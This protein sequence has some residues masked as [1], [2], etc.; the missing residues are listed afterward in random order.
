[1]N[2][3]RRKHDNLLLYISVNTLSIR[4]FFVKRKMLLK[5]NIF[6]CMRP[7]YACAKILRM[8]Y[9]FSF[10]ATSLSTL[11]IVLIAVSCV[12]FLGLLF[13]VLYFTVFR[14]A[15]TAKL[16]RETLKKYE[17]AHSLLFGD[18]NKYIKRLE[19]IASMNLSYAEDCTAYK[20]RYSDLRDT[21]DQMAGNACDQ[22][23]GLLDDKRYKDIRSEFDGYNEIITEYVNMVDDLNNALKSKFQEEE[24]TNAV[25]IDL[26]SKLRTLKQTYFNEQSQLALLSHSFEMVFTKIDSC[27]DEAN[28]NIESANYVKANRILR[29]TVDPIISEL[30][31]L[32]VNLPNM[33]LSAQNI[34][35]DKLSSLKYRYEELSNE[36]YPLRDIITP[37]KFVKYENEIKSIVERLKRFEVDGMQ[38]EIDSILTSFEKY[39]KALDKE[40]EANKVFFS[41]HDTIYKDQQ[42][43]ENRWVNLCHALPDIKKIFA[44]SA[45]DCQMVDDIKAKVDISSGTKRTLDTFEHSSNRQPYTILVEKM[46][47]LRDQTNGSLNQIDNF[48]KHLSDMKKD[49][50]SA[51]NDL[52]LYWIKAREAE[53][54]IRETNI[55]KIQKKYSPSI[56]TIFDL[57]D[58]LY[59]KV[60]TVP[61]D[62]IAANE[63]HKELQDTA[64][65]VFSLL[66]KESESLHEAEECIV[67]RNRYRDC[68]SNDSLLHQA[69]GLFMDG[70]F[71]S[72]YE[73]ASST[74]DPSSF[75]SDNL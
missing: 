23:D 28:T 20:R 12:V 69:E 15:K 4:G 36:G 16:V 19:H 60:S 58:S 30:S 47:E 32:I 37:D 33:C 25:L 39:N 53:A 59:K 71:S 72:A 68:L 5:E 66:N 34:L 11:S 26:G 51:N 45:N 31:R 14:N 56:D 3:V 8:S 55:E 42:R 63:I 73:M 57:I 65:S 64:N 44:F 41:E 9:R 62:V 61:I 27:F 70:E 1:M 54:L 50:E 75:Q 6:P 21:T 49:V 67:F 46:H 18:I 10:L 40:V 17:A 74:Q 43:M 7:Y 48:Q 38:D 24:D 52:P 29:G 35:P 13:C 22:L 2:D